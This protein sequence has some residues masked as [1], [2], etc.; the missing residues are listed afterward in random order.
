M[1]ALS[2]FL[3]LI[4]A[5]LAVSQNHWWKL[6]STAGSWKRNFDRKRDTSSGVNAANA[7]NSASWWSSGSLWE[8]ASIDVNLRLIESLS[9]SKWSMGRGNRWCVLSCKSFWNFERMWSKSSFNVDLPDQTKRLLKWSAAIMLCY[10]AF[11]RNS[12]CLAQQ[13]SD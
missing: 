2:P 5:A 12:N 7:G 8:G 1:P 10:N 4:L 6:G 3:L 11:G 13:V 9:E